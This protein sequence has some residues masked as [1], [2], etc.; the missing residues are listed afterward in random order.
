MNPPLN[1]GS[2]IVIL[3]EHKELNELKHAV[4]G[5]LGTGG[6]AEAV[7]PLEARQRLPETR[8]S[9]TPQIPPPPH[10]KALVGPIGGSP[11]APPGQTQTLK[12]QLFQLELE[13]PDDK[14]PK[15]FWG[16]FYL[17]KSKPKN[18]FESHLESCGIPNRPS[19]ESTRSS[20]SSST[21]CQAF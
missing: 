3:R 1:P 6:R 10:E 4:P 17:S 12:T 8:T 18:P 16:L 20:M 21:P 19:K 2:R 11:R 15:G 5:I 13:I 7:P 14:V 9:R